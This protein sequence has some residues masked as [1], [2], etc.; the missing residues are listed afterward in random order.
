MSAQAKKK[1]ESDRNLSRA[2]Q[3][4]AGEFKAEL[5]D[6]RKKLLV[7][8]D[9]AVQDAEESSEKAKQQAEKTYK[10]FLTNKDRLA[11]EKCQEAEAKR[12]ADYQDAMKRFES[13]NSVADYM[14]A[15]S[16]H[17]TRTARKWS[18]VVMRK[19]GG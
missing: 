16:L 4:A 7:R 2:R 12:E 5:E 14:N 1:Y 3:F 6:L 13:A 19:Q 18:S 17:R 15:K 8:L 11:K 10:S 9:K